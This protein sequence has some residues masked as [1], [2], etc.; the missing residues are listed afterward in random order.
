[1]TT[2][3]ITTLQLRVKAL[4]E[5]EKRLLSIV[6]ELLVIATIGRENL[7]GPF[8]QNA[9][10]AARMAVGTHAKEKSRAA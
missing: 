2:A 4:E 7:T 6:T 3:E 5:S 8:V 9:V 10:A 1:M